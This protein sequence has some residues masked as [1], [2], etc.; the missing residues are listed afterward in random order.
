LTDDVYSERLLR[1]DEFPVKEINQNIT[2]PRV[3]RVLPQLNDRTTESRRW[4][5][6]QTFSDWFGHDSLKHAQRGNEKGRTESIRQ[7]LGAAS[8]F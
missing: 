7:P 6:F 5:L 1:F 4:D 3:Q 2:F 8:K